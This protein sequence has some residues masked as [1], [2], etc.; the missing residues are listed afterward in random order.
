MNDHIVDIAR[1]WIGTPYFHQASAKGRGTDCLGL[2]RGVWREVL[3]PEPEVPPTYSMDWGEVEGREVLK[4]AALR[5]LIA[6]PLAEIAVGD[7]LLFK[8]RSNALAKHLGIQSAIGSYPKFIHAYSGH[9]VTES[10]LSAP[11]QRKIVARFS[12][13][14]LG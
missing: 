1:D 7:V 14:T 12:F 3:G 13:P 10:P 2:I 11:W 4:E 6:K 9:C 8:M 5:H